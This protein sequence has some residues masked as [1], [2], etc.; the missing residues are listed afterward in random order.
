MW[1]LDGLKCK[2]N[3]FH[4]RVAV[5]TRFFLNRARLWEQN[6]LVTR[7]QR[8]NELRIMAIQYKPY[9]STHGWLSC[10]V[11]SSGFAKAK[12]PIFKKL[13]STGI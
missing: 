7:K 9:Q 2:T 1:E 11:R 5:A 8:K 3:K 6:T 10:R 4:F 13:Y 12:Y